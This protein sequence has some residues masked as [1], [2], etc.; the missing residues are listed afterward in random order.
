MPFLEF[1]ISFIGRTTFSD[2][3]H[4]LEEGRYVPMRG[5]RFRVAQK[6]KKEVGPPTFHFPILD[7]C[8]IWEEVLDAI[9][10]TD[11]GNFK[12]ENWRMSDLI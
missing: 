10:E 7:N 5:T 11:N 2:V 1:P 3:Y 4:R 9:I 6:S 8:D 12:V